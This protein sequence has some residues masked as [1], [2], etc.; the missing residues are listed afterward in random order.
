MVDLD[1][2]GV[3]DLVAREHVLGEHVG[4]AAGGAEAPVRHVDANDQA[5]PARQLGRRR[6]LVDLV[7]GAGIFLGEPVLEPPEFHLVEEGLCFR[8]GLERLGVRA[9]VI[10]VSRRRHQ[11]LDD[12]DILRFQQIGQGNAA[13]TG[14]RVRQKRASVEQVPGNQISIHRLSRPCSWTRLL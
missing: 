12:H 11:F 14:C 13:E 8:V 9:G 10:T 2:R 7:V 1:P 6:R 4:T 3:A 5:R